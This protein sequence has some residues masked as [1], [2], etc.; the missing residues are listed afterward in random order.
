MRDP[1]SRARGSILRQAAAILCALLVAC[2]ALELHNL[3]NHHSGID[4]GQLF[5]TAGAHPRIPHHIDRSE[6]RRE[7][8]CATCTLQGQA[9]GVRTEATGPVAPAEI[10]RSA[11]TP[12][13]A[14][15]LPA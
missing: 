9:R 8:A 15:D 5:E 12:Q 1:F 2:G 7:P 3:A 13:D 14:P 4:V 11:L 6:E 10:H